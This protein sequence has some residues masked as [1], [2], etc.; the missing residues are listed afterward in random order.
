M[1]EYN[2]QNGIIQSDNTY[3]AIANNKTVAITLQRNT[4]NRKGL[5]NEKLNYNV[6]YTNEIEISEK[7]SIFED[8]KKIALDAKKRCSSA[9]GAFID[10][11]P[12][13][14]FAIIELLSEENYGTELGEYFYYNNTY[15]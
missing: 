9:K 3:I 13:G 4:F 10:Y 11:F 1:L 7:D 14:K 2:Y 8:I 15:I 12:E 5:S 6:K